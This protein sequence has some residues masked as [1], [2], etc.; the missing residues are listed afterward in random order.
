MT[1]ARDLANLADSATG[2]E[3]AWTS[4]TPSWTA[5]TTNPVINNGTITGKYKQIG[6]TVF[7]SV[8]VTMGSTTTYGTGEWRI[9]LPVTAA[10]AKGVVVN[11]LALDSGAAWYHGLAL[12][13]WINSTTT[14]ALVQSEGGSAISGFTSTNPMTW[15]TNDEFFITGIY[16]AA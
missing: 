9:S 1:F 14:I 16:E 10:S 5:V 2:I 11:L 7:F 12:S 4:Y 3:S 6:K 8:F 13:A 15:A